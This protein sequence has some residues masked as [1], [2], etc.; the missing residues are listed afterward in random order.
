MSIDISLRLS[1]QKALLDAVPIGLRA[2]SIETKNAMIFFRCIFDSQQSKDDYWESLS[3]A[4]TEIISD[5]P[6]FK[7][8]EEFLVNNDFNHIMKHFKHLVFM[9]KETSI[10]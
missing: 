9:R 7:I 3:I 5:F 4:G 10:S 2:V 1:A 8:F 6:D